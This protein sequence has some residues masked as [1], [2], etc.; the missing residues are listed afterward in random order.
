MKCNQT[1]FHGFQDENPS[2]KQLRIQRGAL[3]FIPGQERDTAGG[4]IHLEQGHGPLVENVTSLPVSFLIYK[5][6][7]MLT[8]VVVVVMPMPLD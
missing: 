5:L 4:T 1:F 7:K 6:R 3:Q 8:K 2:V